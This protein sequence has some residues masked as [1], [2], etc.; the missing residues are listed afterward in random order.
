MPRRRAVAA[1]AVAAAG[2]LSAC[3]SSAPV[4]QPPAAVQQIVRSIQHDGLHAS[5]SLSVSW[6][7]TTVGRWARVTHVAYRLGVDLTATLLVVEVD[8]DQVM[9]CDLCISSWMSGHRPA[10]RYVVRTSGAAG[11]DGQ[12]TIIGPRRAFTL[13][14]LGRVGTAP[15]AAGTAAT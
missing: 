15:L 5:G 6:T 12:E 14:Q 10:G 4:A 2:C 7:T 8:S 11:V 13:D 3:S 9:T 1:S